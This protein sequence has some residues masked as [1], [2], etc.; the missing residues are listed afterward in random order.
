MRDRYA[1]E[2][3][4]PLVQT[5][6]RTR[7]QAAWELLW[8]IK[9]LYPDRITP[10]RAI[11]HAL[12]DASDFD[13][14]D[15]DPRYVE[16]ERTFEKAVE[17]WTVAQ[18]VSCDAVDQAVKDFALGNTPSGGLTVGYIDERGREFRPPTLTAYPHT[19][20]REEFLAKADR[21]YNSVV[22]FYTR[23]GDTF[24][25]VKREL[26]HFDWLAAHYVGGLSFSNIAKGKTPFHFTG[27]SEK[28]VAGECRKLA[29]LIGLP[30]RPRRG[31]RPAA[32]VTRAA[33]KNAR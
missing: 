11:G 10:L 33:G 32:P 8:A 22:E 17:Q 28:T 29:A 23:R 16:P 2:I 5:T 20:T 15:S 14:V 18:N 27:K 19:E 21:Y 3:A 1:P 13:W 4:K 7:E 6:E 24:G 25:T 31:R 26:E 12:R 30:P 9:R